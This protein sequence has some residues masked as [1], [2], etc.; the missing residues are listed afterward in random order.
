MRACAATD[1]NV[2]LQTVPTMGHYRD[3]IPNSYD[4]DQSSEIIVPYI[5]QDL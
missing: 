4:Y 5:K 3:V 1:S 2:Q